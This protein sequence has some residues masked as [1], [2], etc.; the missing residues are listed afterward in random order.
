MSD[1]VVITETGRSGTTF[2]I[3]LL[4]RLGLDI[5]FA[6]RILV[7]HET[8]RAGLEINLLEAAPPLYI[9]RDPAF[10]LYLKEVSHKY[11][12]LR[13]YLVVLHCGFVRK[14]IPTPMDSALGR[15]RRAV[16]PVSVPGATSVEN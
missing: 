8:A 5:D 7:K 3:E 9:I 1:H 11:L 10:G 2:L 13:S 14:S 16:T 6:P 12:L 15:T 4:T